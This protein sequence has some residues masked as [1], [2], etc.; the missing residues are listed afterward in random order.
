M[1]LPT[2]PDCFRIAIDWK[3]D[4]GFTATNVIHVLAPAS[5]ETAVATLVVSSFNA[6]MWN[7]VYTNAF[8]DEVVVT[9]L[10]GTPDG[11]VFGGVFVGAHAPVGGFNGSGGSQSIPQGCALVKL[12]TAATGR[13]GRGRVFLPWLGESSQDGGAILGVNQT[14]TTSGWVD[15]S[16][17]LVAGSMALAVASYKHSTASQVLNLACESRSATQRKRQHR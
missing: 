2:I 7:T 12:A 3:E 6:N 10:D 5:D 17:A 16:N 8:I 9:K 15:F 14:N 4:H 13:S 11:Q 1:P